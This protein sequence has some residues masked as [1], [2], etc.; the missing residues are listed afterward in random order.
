MLLNNAAHTYLRNEFC[1]FVVL[2]VDESLKTFTHCTDELRVVLEGVR[3]NLVELGLNS[4]IQTDKTKRDNRE[5]GMRTDSALHIHDNTAA[6]DGI[7]H[8]Q[9]TKGKAVRY[10]AEATRF[11]HTS[12]VKRFR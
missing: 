6:H 4:D 2:S 8:K 3:G 9:D 10:T 12:C 1:W 11:G 5:S 7:G